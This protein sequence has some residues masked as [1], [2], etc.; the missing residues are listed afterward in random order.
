MV[1]GRGRRRRRLE[2]LVRRQLLQRN[3]VQDVTY[4]S[5]FEV[6]AAA[7]AAAAAF[8]WLRFDEVTAVGRPKM[9]SLLN[10]FNV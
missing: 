1:D 10:S 6:A 9:A 3:P 5:T 8:K 2:R 7:A 4:G